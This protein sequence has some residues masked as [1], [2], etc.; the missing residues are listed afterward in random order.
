MDRR[1]G[2]QLRLF[3]KTLAEGRIFYDPGIKLER[4]STAKPELKRR[5][6]I[7]GSSADL[8]SLYTSTRMVKVCG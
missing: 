4:A 8:E 7:R 6:Q 1:K 3:V 5:S 2:T